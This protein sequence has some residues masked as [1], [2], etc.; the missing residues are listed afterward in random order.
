LIDV[1]GQVR[2]RA[3]VFDQPLEQSSTN[4]FDRLRIILGVDSNTWRTISLLGG[5]ACIS[6]NILLGMILVVRRQRSRSKVKIGVVSIDEFDDSDIEMLPES[7]IVISVPDEED[8]KEEVVTEVTVESQ[9]EQPEPDSKEV[10]VKS[11]RQERRLKRQQAK[12]LHELGELP[13]PPPPGSPS[14][15]DLPPPPGSPSL[16]DLPPP[17][18]PSTLG[19]AD[20]QVSCPSCTAV[21]TLRNP[22]ISVVDCPVCDERF[23]V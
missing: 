13:L 18:N 8:E 10:H 14:L 6:A 4:P 9:E 16:G 22:S 19:M 1:L 5:V 21:F 11:P 2:L 17:P 7:P 23:G 12:T 15:G 3:L 20:R